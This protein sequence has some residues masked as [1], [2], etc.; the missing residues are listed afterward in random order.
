M[1]LKD[2]V[3]R[4]MISPHANRGPLH[5][6]HSDAPEVALCG[7]SETVVRG[8]LAVAGRPAAAGCTGRSGD[9]ADGRL[10]SLTPA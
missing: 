9:W 3:I 6:T 4:G 2:Y 7:R 1:A 5:T 10:G 8:A